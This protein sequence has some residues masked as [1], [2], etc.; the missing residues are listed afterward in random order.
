MFIAA[1]FSIA[2]TWK[3]AECSLMDE[4]IKKMKYTYTM[5]C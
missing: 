3:H 4:R 5:E 2:K 1:L